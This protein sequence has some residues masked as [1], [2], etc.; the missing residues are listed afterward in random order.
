M[1]SVNPLYIPRNHQVE[2]AIENAIAGNLST[3]E[4]LHT[5]L[6]NPFQEQPES[7][8]YAEPPLPEQRVTQTF[9]GT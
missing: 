5:V 9:C 6:K 1:D 2:N 4:E 7:A 3:F 8:H